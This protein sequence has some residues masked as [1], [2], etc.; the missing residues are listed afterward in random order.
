MIV[1]L[2]RLQVVYSLHTKNDENEEQ[3]ET[4]TSEHLK[5]KQR[6]ESERDVTLRE[7]NEE[8]I[9]NQDLEKKIADLEK[10]KSTLFIEH[11]R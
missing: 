7:R 5:E 11:V 9:R 4:L 8:R 2:C 3:L 10:D 1:F 6:L